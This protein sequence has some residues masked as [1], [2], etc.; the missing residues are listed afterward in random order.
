MGAPHTMDF[1]LQTKVQEAGA[2]SERVATSSP[3]RGKIPKGQGTAC[4]EM[5][6]ERSA[7]RG[8]KASREVGPGAVR[9]GLG[10]WK[11]ESGSTDAPSQACG[12][13]PGG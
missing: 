3:L 9:G 12:G 13:S 8:P 7:R 6:L 2:F 5:T 11:T 4:R 10:R 1:T